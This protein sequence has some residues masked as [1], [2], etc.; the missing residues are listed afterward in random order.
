M[1]VKKT[2]KVSASIEIVTVIL[3]YRFSNSYVFTEKTKVIPIICK[4]VLNSFK[5]LYRVTRLTAIQLIHHDYQAVPFFQV[6]DY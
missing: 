5:Q 2:T 6:K 4:V 3:A 1:E